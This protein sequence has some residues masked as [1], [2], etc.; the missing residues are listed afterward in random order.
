[1]SFSLDFALS[2]GAGK[3]G[4]ADLRAYFFSSSGTLV[5]GITNSGF[6]AF[7]G[8]NYL[9]HCDYMIDS[10]RGGVAFY[11]AATSGA[12]LAISAINPQEVENPD[13]K[14]SQATLASGSL[15][16]NSY[17]SGFIT[18]TLPQNIHTWNYSGAPSVSGQRCL[19][20]AQRK[21]INKWDL[22]GNSG[23]LTVYTENDSTIAYLQ[24]V[25]ATSGA[26]PITSL[27]TN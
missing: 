3:S 27:D 6:T 18:I 1:M 22:T 16:A 23:H 25:G 20:N 2:L 7:G 15:D 21:L 26:A 9:W 17:S 10:F 19:L 14:T 13:I 12:L 5:S 4:L 24:A 11:S 8:G